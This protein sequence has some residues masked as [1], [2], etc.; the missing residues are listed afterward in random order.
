MPELILIIFGAALASAF[1]FLTGFGLG[2]ILLPVYL[3]A[4]GPALAVAAVAPVHLFHNLGKF[5]LLR[6]HVDRRILVQFGAPALAAAALGAW[7]LARLTDL[8]ELG[9]WSLF[10][11]TFS[12]C[13]LKLVIG[14]SLAVF[15]GWELLG[16]GGCVRRV[17]LWVGGFAS[18]LLG[19]LTGHQGAIRSAFFLGKNLPKETFI[20]T[21]AAVACVV[22]FTRLAVYVQLFR[23]LGGSVP[24]PVI[25]AGIAGAAVGLWI[26][27]IGLRNAPAC[28]FRRI[29]GIALMVFG[30]GLASG[31][32]S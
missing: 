13:P 1:T 28:T 23:S 27:R 22:D 19:G 30:L 8:P 17:P 16:G 21:G 12:L 4:M 15:S 7:G 2:T 9:I 3:L 24:W 25:G 31:V 14:L 26:G 6:S 32:I 18:G 5:M 29:I 20:A 10:G 11:K